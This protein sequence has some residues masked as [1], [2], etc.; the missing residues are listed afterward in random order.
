[1]ETR[2]YKFSKNT[3]LQ[4]EWRWFYLVIKSTN[5]WLRKLFLHTSERKKSFSV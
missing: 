2:R 1:M 5:T 3:E 4:W